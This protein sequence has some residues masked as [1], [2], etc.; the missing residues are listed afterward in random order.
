MESFVLYDYPPRF[1]D[2]GATLAGYVDFLRRP[3]FNPKTL[4]LIQQRFATQ[5]E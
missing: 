3:G 4:K 2:G 1:I 5:A